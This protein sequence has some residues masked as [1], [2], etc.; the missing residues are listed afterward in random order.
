MRTNKTL[1]IV[2]L[3]LSCAWQAASA[4]QPSATQRCAEML[5][6]KVT[7]ETVQVCAE[8]AKESRQ[9]RLM[10]GFALATQGD[11]KGAIEYYSKV[12]AGIDVARSSEPITVAAL[13][14]RASA[15]YRT[16]QDDLAFED[17]LAYLK[18]QP[19]DA[20]L[21]F[22]AASTAPSAEVGLS[23][24]EKAVALMP[25]D[26]DVLALHARRLAKLDRKR[27][28]L[29]AIEKASKLA[30]SKA[31]A[32]TEKGMVH[33]YLGEYARAEKFFA[34]A[35]QEDPSDTFIKTKRAD[36]LRDLRRHKEAIAVASEVLQVEPDNTEALYIRASSQ[37]DM[38]DGEA[39]LADIQRLK[40][41]AP[42]WDASNDE[43]RAQKTALA[44]R[45][46]TSSGLPQLEA[47]RNTVVR[48][49]TRHL[50]S[51]CGNLRLPEFSLDLDIDQLNADLDRYGDCLNEWYKLPELA[52]TDN[53]A[54]AENQAFDRL[55]D[56]SI[57][58]DFAEELRCSKMLK[59][60]KCIND[61]I[62]AKA[63]P[64]VDG[65]DN[66]IELVT[67]AEANRLNSQVAALN[68][69][70]NRH[71]RNVAI[72]DFL[73]DLAEALNE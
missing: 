53:L 3:T 56:A 58:F 62:V 37:L 11:S 8:A 6:T 19:D 27:E 72:A 16:R 68:K 14:A 73:H 63:R 24:A 4:Q 35:L 40:Q 17:A 55:I 18:H 39:A 30:P 45:V 50:R 59:G 43:E 64:I 52:V 46:F 49:F 67:K 9:G 26:F 7:E 33:S 41:L 36:T 28:A 31:R 12:L 34:Q 1:P 69:G 2:A 54:P 42:D 15:Y 25:D 47:D 48:A 71:N 44:H 5:Q 65:I 22:I 57:A 70:I 51:K 32:L 38:G 13:G 10:Y 61:A 60:S 23:Y 29:A 66:P 21:L 20:N